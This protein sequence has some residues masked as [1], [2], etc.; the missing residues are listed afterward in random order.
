[1]EKFGLDI[2][3]VIYED[4]HLLVVNKRSSDI[5]QKDI[6]GDKALVELFKDYLKQKYN[7]PGQVFLGI[8]HRLDRPT[9]GV[10]VFAK[11]SKSLS[12]LNEM[13]R[14]KEIQKTYW[15]VVK[16]RPKKDKDTLVNYL[17]KKELK[18]KSFPVAKSV[19]GAKYSELDYKLIDSSDNYHLIE[20]LPKTGRHHQIRV[21]LSNIG[22]PIKGDLKYGF[23]RPNPG[24]SI[25]L[26]A[27]KLELIHPVKKE[28]MVFVAPTHEDPLWNYFRDKK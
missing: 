8:P 20:V 11:T 4:N 26:H 9:S 23:D 2:P 7:K 10:I 17:I 5:V 6:T 22:C 24:G 3:D 25:H 1:M 16:N 13:F 21:Q 14:N 28:T 15:A 12:R 18:N 19:S 27:R